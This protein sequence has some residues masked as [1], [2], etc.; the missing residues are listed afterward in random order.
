MRKAILALLT[1]CIFFGLALPAYAADEIDQDQQEE[2]Q[3]QEPQEPT[4]EEQQPGEQQETQ[5][6]PVVVST[7]EELQTAIEAA[8][9]GDTIVL[10]NR[11]NIDSIEQDADSI[12]IGSKEKKITLFFTVIAAHKKTL[13]S[14]GYSYPPIHVFSSLSTNVI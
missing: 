4:Q 11:I 8:E 6:S 14:S 3:V 7:L 5:D 1:L 9:D 10:L 12:T 2:T 13:P